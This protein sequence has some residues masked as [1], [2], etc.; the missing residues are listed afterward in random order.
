ME[1]NIQNVFK[2]IFLWYNTPVSYLLKR[3]ERWNW[4]MKA[5]YRK[6][7]KRKAFS[8]SAFAELHRFKIV[9]GSL[10]LVFAIVFAAYLSTRGAKAASSGNVATV[11]VAI[12]ESK[13]AADYI[14]KSAALRETIKEAY[15][16]YGIDSNISCT[17]VEY[18]ELVIDGQKVAN[19]PSEREANKLLDYYRLRYV[20]ESSEVLDIKFAQNVV[21]RK[22]RTSIAKF[23]GFE[24]EEKI[25]EHI[26]VG[27]SELRQHEVQYGENYW[28]IAQNYGITIEDLEAANPNVDPEYLTIGQMISLV[29]PRSLLTVITEE[30]V[31][32]S[33]EVEYETVYEDSDS[34]YK[35]ESRVKSSGEYGEVAVEAK[36]IKENGRVISKAVLSE[37]V[38]S[39]PVSKVVYVGTM[40][41]PPRMGTGVLGYPLSVYGIVT[42]EFGDTWGRGGYPHRG[43]DVQAYEGTP[44]LASD[45]G[46][47]VTATWSYSYGYYVVIDHGGNIDT[48]YA[49]CSS[50]AVSPGDQVFKGQTIA[51][52]GSTGVST[53]GHLHFEVRLNGT[54][55][56]PR[57]YLDF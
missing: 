19:F 40:D 18:A 32:Y 6:N 42:S 15:A 12:P 3:K 45:G 41:P 33:E 21:V 47:V 25:K 54:L 24:S 57:W 38:L 5:Y 34:L 46:V 53:G 16:K 43:I 10:F 36:L 49:H 39:E 22:V 7:Q 9:L 52:S 56:N 13:L 11:K 8:I 55:Q 23:S 31:A 4:S 28:V 26:E 37:K 2:Y 20:D 29:A 30:K 44:V 35:G 17:A 48:L 27:T 50:L 51:Y 14:A 1:L